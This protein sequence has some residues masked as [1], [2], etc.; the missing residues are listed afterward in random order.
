M[1]VLAYTATEKATQLLRLDATGDG[2]V[3]YA[4]LL[5]QHVTDEPK[6]LAAVAVALVAG[7]DLLL[8]QGTGRAARSVPQPRASPR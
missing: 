8:P 5:I 3:N 1:I 6:R 4:G 2:Y 7:H